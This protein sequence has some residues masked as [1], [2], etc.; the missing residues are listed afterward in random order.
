MFTEDEAG[1]ETENE[2]EFK[3]GQKLTKMGLK[4][5]MGL[6]IELRLGIW[7]GMGKRMWLKITNVSPDCDFILAPPPAA[8]LQFTFSKSCFRVEIQFDDGNYERW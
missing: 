6:D 7:L 8:P 1:D 2:A 3:M 4:H 5:T